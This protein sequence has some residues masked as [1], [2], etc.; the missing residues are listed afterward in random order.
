MF[1]IMSL[2]LIGLLNVQIDLLSLIGMAV[3]GL[4]ML[5]FGVGTWFAVNERWADLR[6]G[7]VLTVTGVAEPYVR[8]RVRG[9]AYHSM[10]IGKL[11]FPLP[12][13]THH[14]FYPGNRYQIFYTPKAKFIVSAVRLDEPPPDERD[15]F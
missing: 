1:F 4:L 14:A 2:A 5:V 15:A 12:D 13:P 9:T 10:K 6:T 8:S 3:V 7:I 11:D